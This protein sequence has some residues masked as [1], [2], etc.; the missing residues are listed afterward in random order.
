A[1][2]FEMGFCIQCHRDNKATTDCFTCH[3]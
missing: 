3:R 1:R 2:K